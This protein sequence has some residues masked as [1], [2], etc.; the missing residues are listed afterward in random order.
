MADGFNVRIVE[1]EITPALQRTLDATGNL[2]P[3]LQ[4]IGEHLLRSTDDNFAKQRDPQGRP[5]K[6]LKVLSY[7]LA[8]TLGQKK[9]THTKTG[10]LTAGFQRYIGSRK[11][12]T[13]SGELRGSIKYNAS[14]T[15]LEV[16][17]GKVYSA[18]HQFG[19][20]AGRGRKVTIPA[21]PYLGI[22]PRDRI[23]ILATLKSRI[24][25]AIKS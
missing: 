17:S 15:R 24:E 2:K 10:G 13:D 19:G 7:H 18:T 21:R 3:A 11:I 1:D 12:L 8:Y 16:G 5:W 22:G 6:P 20:K 4:A 14:A 9:R 25:T 23:E